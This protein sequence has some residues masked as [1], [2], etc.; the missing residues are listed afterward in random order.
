MIRLIILGYS[1]NITISSLCHYKNYCISSNQR[2][3]ILIFS[4]FVVDL[5][6]RHKLKYC[7]FYFI[8]VDQIDWI[9]LVGFSSILTICLDGGRG[10][11][12]ERREGEVFYELYLDVSL[13]EDGKEFGLWRGSNPSFLIFPNWRY[14]EGRREGGGFKETYSRPN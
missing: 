9:Y 8:R 10:E 4:Q 3:N 13:R 12:V 2:I 6:S 11:G 5:G 14:L 7:I 1:I